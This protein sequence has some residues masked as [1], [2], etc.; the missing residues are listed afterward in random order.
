MIQRVCTHVLALPKAATAVENPLDKMFGGERYVNCLRRQFGR[1]WGGEGGGWGAGHVRDI[2]LIK[3]KC[4]HYSLNLARILSEKFSPF[5][6]EIDSPWNESG[7]RRA[8]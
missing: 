5:T 6:S 3:I 1:V 7:F 8:E 4:L 2:F